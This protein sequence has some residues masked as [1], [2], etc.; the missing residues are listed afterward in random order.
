MNRTALTAA[1]AAAAS[2]AFVSAPALAAPSVTLYG[3][4]DM[5]LS[6]SRSSGDASN[7][8]D[9]KALFQLKS[10]QR[11]GS[12]FGL[13]GVEDLGSGNKVGFILEDQFKADD[14]TLQDSSFWARES[15]LWVSGRYGRVTVGKVGQLKSPVGST[16]LAGTAMYPFGTLMSNFIG[17]LKYIT[18]G[19][20]LT[21]DNSV[22]YVSPNYRGFTFHA[23]YSFA[24]SGQEGT[25]MND[26][27]RMMAAAVRYKQGAL[28]AL[29]LADM[30]HLNT[31]DSKLYDD[32]WTVNLAANYDFGF[33]KPYIFAQYFKHSAFNSV[34]SDY[35][36]RI[37]SGTGKKYNGFGV[38]AAVQWPMFGGKAKVGAGYAKGEGDGSNTTDV[39]RYSAHVG[40]DYS[41]SKR[42][43][44]YAD[45]G[46]VRQ[47]LKNTLDR[48]NLTGAELSAG[49]V[50]RF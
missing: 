11:N 6:V 1:F 20:Y 28:T 26:K 29:A 27:D 41:L 30:I 43:D 16:A 19:N 2:A 3:L 40:Y 12:R 7:A 31:A 4:V 23:Q 46:W 24:M 36:T 25:G 37:S 21:V 10:G 8:N 38:L 14:G 50:H 22:T 17:G 45:L 42:T 44:L 15:S 47:D 9:G 13:K 18:T 39:V 34:G 5:G 35:Q 49:I 48:S 32:P 33:I